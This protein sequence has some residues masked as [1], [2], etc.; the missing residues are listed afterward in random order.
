MAN[1]CRIITDKCVGCG[2]CA[3]NCPT[4]AITIVDRKAVIDSKCVG[5]NICFK[6]CRKD[7]VEKIAV[8][9]GSVRCDCCPVRCNI[10]EGCLGSC[11]RFRNENGE[12]VRIEPINLVEPKEIR[13]NNLTGLPDR[14]LLTG[15]GAG[16]NL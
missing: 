8:P 2:I 11:Q 9:K 4:E 13:I 10:P 12:L 6:V 5:C 7:A 14:P 1:I 15:F 3:K 16:T